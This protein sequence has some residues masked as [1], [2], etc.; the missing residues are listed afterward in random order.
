MGVELEA[1][2]VISIQVFWVVILCRR[3]KVSRPFEGTPFFL[4]FKRKLD[5]LTP[6][7]GGTKIVRNVVNLMTK[8]T[9]SHPWR[10]CIQE[11]NVNV[12]QDCW[13]LHRRIL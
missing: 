2:V 12:T 6:E 7:D 10:P 3:V 5:C 9:A 4:P 11:Q 1:E 8:D 13:L